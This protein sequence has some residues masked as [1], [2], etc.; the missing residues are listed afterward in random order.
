MNITFLGATQ[1]VTG[2]CHLIQINDHKILL[3]CGLIQGDYEQAQKNYDDFPFNPAS[4]DAVILSH[5]HLD[6]SGKLPLLIERGFKGEIF[7]HPATIDLCEVLLEDAGYLNERGA[8]WENK[9]RERQG[10]ELVEPLYTQQQARN[11]L[12]FFKPVPYTHKTTLMSGVTLEFH[13]A[14]HILGS[15]IVELDLNENNHSKKVVFS[16][17]LGHAGAPILKDPTCL[18]KADIVLMESTYGDRLHRNWDDTWEELGSTIRN[19]HSQRGNIL[20][21]AFTVG[22]TQELLYCFNKH[23]DDW[24]LDNWKI[25]LDSPMAIK[26]TNIYSKYSSIYEDDARKDA[27]NCGNPLNL[28][29]LTM[30]SSTE[31]SMALNRIQSGAIIIAGSGMC[32]GGRIKHHL[33]HNLWRHQSHVIIVGFQARNTPG[34]SLVDGAEWL[35]LWGEK[36]RINAKVTTPGGLSA[37]ADQQG[38]IDWYKNFKN[39]PQLVLVHGEPEAQK[40]LA[41]KLNTDLNIKPVIAEYNQCI[42][43]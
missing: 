29:N 13:D 15:C 40:I 6:H 31:D 1:Y 28:P 32:T 8:F 33:K 12:R 34:R 9:K 20:I 42:E 3:D 43:L 16:G 4:I 36:I 7:A 22:R 37:H 17:D 14:G 5:A 41:E 18:T 21:P 19:A 24:Q 38:L 30:T 26:S 27:Q 23:Y 10:L 35:T 25:F 2:S 11:C 39:R